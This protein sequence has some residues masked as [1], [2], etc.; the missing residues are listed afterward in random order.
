VY[1]N[2]VDLVGDKKEVDIVELETRDMLSNNGYAGDDVT[3]IRGSALGALR[4]LDAG[5][6]GPDVE[7]IEQL[8]AAMDRDIPVP[9]AA[10]EQSS[11]EAHARFSAFTYWLTQQEG[12]LSSPITPGFAPQFHFPTTDVTGAIE[13]PESTTGRAMPGEQAVIDVSLGTPAAIEPGER[14]AIRDGG[15]TV[16]A[17]LVVEVR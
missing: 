1:L 10:G 17:G 2:K 15:R 14:F 11:T 6:R 12:G 5:K 3:V 8:L 7:A 4:E 9:Q 13:M 16:G